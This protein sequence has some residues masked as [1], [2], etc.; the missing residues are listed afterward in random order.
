[1]VE[2]TKRIRATHDRQDIPRVISARSIP[3][4]PSVPMIAEGQCDCACAEILNDAGL[5]DLDEDDSTDDCACDGDCACA[6][7]IAYGRATGCADHATWRVPPGCRSLPLADDYHVAFN[8]V[9]GGL[10]VLNT[11]ALTL[12]RTF[13]QPQPPAARACNSREAQRS[14]SELHAVG[15]LEADRHT[16]ARHPGVRSH[17]LTVWLHL[18]DRCNLRCGYCYLPHR[19]DTL[20]PE[21]GQQAI[22]AAFRSAAAHN[23][24]R[25]KFKYAGGEPLLQWPLVEQLHAQAVAL[26]RTTGRALDG[27]VLSNGTLLTPEVAR[28]IQTSDLRLMVSLDS[29]DSA[30]VAGRAQVDGRS[31]HP[32]AMRGIECALAVGLKPDVS[33][34][35]SATSLAGLS[36]LLDWIL[37]RDLRFSLNFV[38]ETDQN[39]PNL[40]PAADPD[41]FVAGLQTAYRTIA[42]RV[43]RFSLLSS[44][45][46]RTNLAGPHR[47]ACSAGY[48]YLVIDTQG[49]IAACQMAL[50]QAVTS[51][52][53]FDPMGALR[54]A[55]DDA[56]FPTVDDKS[57]CRTCD[58]R[59]WCGGG[60]P[61]QARRA[62]GRSDAPS[63]YCQ[64]YQALIPELVRLE[65][66]RLLKYGDPVA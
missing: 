1:M 17:T 40:S 12:W 51:V 14:L 65:G 34:T 13:D 49:Q 29:I 36:R 44:A 32:A 42:A 26:A 9:S 4:E 55:Q 46:D 35:V 66:L 52:L 22:A 41:R 39:D 20:S 31:S 59:Y 63:P 21:A 15:L 45:L 16:T 2:Q 6:T 58:W 61:L 23:Y 38:R 24:Q 19:P 57:I 48:D 30:A 43:P 50:D 7:D 10:V 8:P 27:V 53:D 18:T 54:A 37:D 11:A 28:R 60:C 3:Q 47:R 33:V 56:I 62:T 5:T 64:I 25:L